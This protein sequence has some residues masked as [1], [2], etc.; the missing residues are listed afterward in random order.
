MARPRVYVN[1]YGKPVKINTGVSFNTARR[2]FYI[3][4]SDGHRQEYKTW[5]DARAALATQWAKSIS[6]EELARMAAVAQYRGDLAYATL[7]SDSRFRAML[8]GVT[9]EGPLVVPSMSYAETVVS[10]A[11]TAN[12]LADQ[13]GVPR[14]RIEKDP[15]TLA[16][17]P[18]LRHVIERWTKHKTEEKGRVT[19]HHCA[20][21]RLWSEFVKQ[22]GNVFVAEL[23]PEHFRRFHSWV[24]RE[25]K[26]WSSS[27]WQHDRVSKV[28]SVITFVRKKYPE[29]P[30][31]VGVLEWAGSHD[32]KPFRPK[33]SN[34]EP[35]PSEA[36]A[37]LIEQCR[38]WARIDPKMQDATTQCGRA[39]RGQARR[40]QRD[41]IQFEAILR[42]GLNC[43]LDPIDIERLTWDD[44]KLDSGTPHLR[45]PRLKV[46]GTVGEA[47]ERITPL[48]P[49][50]VE[51]LRRWE[52]YEKPH[53]GPVFRT[54]SKGRY[55]RNRV[56]HT[57]KR[58]RNEA[59]VEDRWS[60]KHLRNVGPTLG[61][62]A[63]RSSDER[64]AFLGHVVHGT[65]RFYEGDVDE[66]Y[67]IPLVNL[68]GAEYFDGE[69]VGSGVPRS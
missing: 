37:A 58:L 8:D 14:M 5:D 63:R 43:G 13:V 53:A 36:F 61:K 62:R 1:Q 19:P 40:Q 29:W 27:Q 50:T 68:I 60:F 25:G 23:S 31:P 47:I 64:E 42:L 49:S 35:L 6:A 48:L 52:E 44:L 66:T 45:L 34:R 26:K 65:S 28:K 67:L 56:S 46:E 22:V 59:H 7:H 38:R 3:I 16:T 41:G 55:Y 24:A 30:W 54:A 18:R 15:K 10:Y 51:S 11:E 20:V 2:R 17:G 12:A 32:V 21:E 69:Q 4:P 33:A 57:I 39:K 9:I